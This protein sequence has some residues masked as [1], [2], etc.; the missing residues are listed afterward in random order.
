LIKD[1]KVI[2]ETED[3]QYMHELLVI[4]DKDVKEI[5]VTVAKHK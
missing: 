3:L 1:G 4:N 2:D 5:V